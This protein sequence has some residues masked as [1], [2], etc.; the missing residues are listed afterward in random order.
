VESK[1]AAEFDVLS[2]LKL[3]I[4][5]GV[6]KLLYLPGYCCYFCRR[7]CLYNWRRHK[8]PRYTGVAVFLWRYI[9]VGH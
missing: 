5:F 9:I 1:T 2:K 7:D 4:V 3:Q 8:I 6:T